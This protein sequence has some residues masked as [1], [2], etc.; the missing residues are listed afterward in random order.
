[1]PRPTHP[2]K[3]IESALRYAQSRGWKV[4]EGEGIV[5]ESSIVHGTVQIAGAV[6][7]VSSASGVRQKPRQ[8]CPPDQTRGQQ[9]CD[10]KG[11]IRRYGP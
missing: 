4:I 1:M 9:L 2:N 6:N 7:S 10:R 8:F 11:S 5:G 3:E